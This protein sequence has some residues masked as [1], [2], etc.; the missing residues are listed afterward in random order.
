MLDWKGLV[1]GIQK[2]VSYVGI[3]LVQ[4]CLDL[5]LRYGWTGGVASVRTYLSLG[6]N[7]CHKPIYN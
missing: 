3:G 2:N 5:I 1:L 4:T 7:N 6:I